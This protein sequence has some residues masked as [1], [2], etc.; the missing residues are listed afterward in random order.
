[1]SKPH[2]AALIEPNTSLSSSGATKTI[3]DLARPALRPLG[4]LRDRHPG[5]RHQ[6]DTR[7]HPQ[8]GEGERQPTQ[9]EQTATGDGKR[10]TTRPAV[11]WCHA[12]TLAIA[13]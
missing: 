7:R 9:E 8:V 1:M 5:R 10:L 11:P 13:K 6:A 4:P 2:R 3:E 12:M